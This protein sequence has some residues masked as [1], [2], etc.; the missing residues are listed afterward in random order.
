MSFLSPFCARL[1]GAALAVSLLAPTG[2][3]FAQAQDATVDM[4]GVKF[5][6]E[7]LHVTPG[8]AVL[9]TN[10]SPLGHTV[11]SE[12]GTY[13]SGTLDPGATFTW[14]FYS[15]GTFAYFCVPHKAIGMVGVIVVEDAASAATSA[16]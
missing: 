10:S 1:L 6:P 3:V 13:D 11:T 4:Q 12:D 2:S 5:I 14:T 9:W 16:A 7:E 8:T 15:P